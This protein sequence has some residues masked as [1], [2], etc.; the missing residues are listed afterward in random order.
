MKITTVTKDF[1]FVVIGDQV[2]EHDREHAENIS[3]PMQHQI[4]VGPHIQPIYQIGQ[5]CRHDKSEDHKE[6]LSP[7]FHQDYER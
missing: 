1:R 2:D 4:E 6:R 3:Q 5:F 7:H